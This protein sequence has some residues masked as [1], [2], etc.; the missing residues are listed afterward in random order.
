MVRK[1]LKNQQGNSLNGFQLRGTDNTRIEALSDGVFA[2][3]IALLVISSSIPETFEQLLIFVEDVV[4]F[5]ICITLLIVIWY[6]H[7]IFFIRYGLKD[8]TTVALNT[9]LLL[10][11]LFYV[12]PLKFLFKILYK[13]A[14]SLI[15][16]DK[17]ALKIL[18]TET[19]PAEDSPQIMVIY[20]IGA[21]LIFISLALLYAYAYRKRKALALSTLE[22]FDTLTSI[23][24]N[25]L[26]AAV[27]ICSVLIAH[28]ELTR[29]PFSAAGM[30]YMIYPIIMPAYGIINGR[31]RKKL[32]STLN[33]DIVS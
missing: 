1:K 9:M 19:M 25:V 11:I 5:A 15:T 22:K 30:F 28:F 18:F 4:P 27:P 3:A 16:N 20:G 2:I 23:K 7:Y 10:L 31:A 14:T 8:A 26:M 29:N 32:I 12:Y 6:Q 33:N 24:I 21:A 17:E 13:L